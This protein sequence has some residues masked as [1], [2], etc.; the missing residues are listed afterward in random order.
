VEVNVQADYYFGGPVSNATVEVVVY[1]NPFFQCWFP[2]REYPWFYDDIDVRSPQHYGGEGQVIKRETLK[3][4]STG[5]LTLTFETPRNAQQDYEYRIEARVTD[6]SRRE[7]VASERVRV[8]RQRYYVYPRPEH[9]LYRPQDKVAINIKAVD[10]NDQPVQVEGRVKL[11]RDYWFEIWLDPDG[12]EVEGDELRRLQEKTQIFPPLPV[13]GR[14]PWQLKFRGYQQDEILAR[15]VKTDS[16]GEAQFA[17]T[18]EREGYYRM[19]WTSQDRGQAPIRAE[20]IVWVARNATTELGYRHGGLEII[21]DKDTFRV[22]KTAAVMFSV[23]TPDRYVLFSVEGEGLYDYQL[24]HVTGTVKLLELPV[25]DRHVPNIFLNAV[26]ISDR[27]I[28]EDTK[29]VVVPPVQH[30]LKMEVKADRPEYQPQEGGTLS[31][32]T[33]DA[34]GKPVSAE[35]ALGVADESVFYI[36]PD[37]AGDP[38]QFFF[39]RKRSHQVSTGSTFNMKTY[40]KLIEGPQAQ[41]VDERALLDTEKDEAAGVMGNERRGGIGGGVYRVAGGVAGSVPGGQIGGVIGGVIGPPAASVSMVAKSARMMRSDMK[42]AREMSTGQLRANAPSEVEEPVVQVRTDFRTTVFWQPDVITDQE[43]KATVQFKYPDSLTSWKATARAISAASQF[44]IA[45]TNTR[46]QKPLIVRL[47]APRFFVVGDSVTISGIINNNTDKPLIITPSLE[48]T[49][50]TLQGAKSVAPIEVKGNGEARIDWTVSVQAQ[51]T[52]RLKVMAHGTKYA[53]AMEKEFPIFEH[54]IEKFLSRSGK[55]RGSEALIKV[56]LP[57]QRKIESTFMNVIVTPSLAVTMLDALPYLIDYPY[58]CTEQTMSRFLPAAVVA[59]TLK[60]LSLEPEQ[61]M[62]HIFGGI[63]PGTANQSHPKGKRDLNELDNMIRQGLDRLYDFQHSDGGWGWWKEGESDHFMSAYVV[64][65]LTLAR[66]AGVTLKVG[67]L[68]RG[69][70]YLDKELVEEENHTDSQAWMLH[71]LAAHHAASKLGTV[72]PNQSRAYKNLWANRDH[73][74]AYTRAL[75]ALCAH[76]YGYLESGKTLIENLENGVKLDSRPDVSVILHGQQST[77]SETMATAH[78]G[79]DGIYWRW[80]DGGVEATAFALRALLAIDPQNKLVEPVMNWLVKNRRGAQ[81]SNTRDTAIVV[82]A[83]NDYLRK[84]GE[85]SQETEYEISVNGSRVGGRRVTPRDVPSA[86]SQWAIDRQILRSGGNEIRILRKSGSAPLYFSVQ[87]RFFSLEEPL[88][89]AASELY[90]HRQYY[91]VTNRPTLLKGFVSERVPFSDG[92]I[93][94][95]GDRVEVLVTFEAKNNYEYLVFEDLKPA[96]LEAVQVRS[97]EPLYARELKAGAVD[98]KN[99]KEPSPSPKTDESDYTGRSRWVYQELRDRKVAL[100]IDKLPQGIWEIHYEL[101]AEIPGKYHALPLL[102]YAMYVPEI[103]AN[104]EETRI[105]I[106][107]GGRQ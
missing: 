16:E 52:A 103:R 12:K 56:E 23:P 87:A 97:G 61:I 1:Q 7:I 15:P 26:L 73:L 48:A 36:Q 30:F 72:G 11:T 101:R 27:Q 57:A 89:A 82:L 6:I 102:G 94:Q 63:E 46:T 80:S 86:P 58:G 3:T 53:D 34:D 68:E 75:L 104:G 2:W 67:V 25:Q 88:T 45:S 74:N 66:E 33:T 90:V 13:P 65:G 5:R 64:W 41:L 10:A 9:N 21:V 107:D 105:T 62:G 42:V 19:A 76:S 38:R 70:N 37:Y 14:R 55:L 60:D 93:L 84:S 35:V 79:E 99:F 49:G 95:S 98:Q 92:G 81:W 28:F 18:P 39:G 29:Q 4:D 8:T 78:W 44:G 71:S 54:G 69:V 91:R 43:G 40:V 47:Q 20:T 96:G 83:M 77:T 100:F 50:V 106:T 22:G 51:G 31:I 59:K 85:L 24:V 32:T 17:F